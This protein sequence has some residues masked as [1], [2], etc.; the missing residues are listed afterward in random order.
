MVFG[1]D[2]FNDKRFAN[3]HQSG[4]DYRILGT[5]SI[6]QGSGA[7]TTIFPVFLG[8]GSTIIQWNPIPQSSQ[9]SNFRTHSGFFSDTWRV[10]GRLTANLGLR[11]DKNDGQ[12]Q[13]H[14]TV[15]T[16]DAWS[17]RLGLI[18]DPTGAG[19]LSIT[20]SVAKYVTAIAQSVAD[21]SAT[22]GNYQT[23]QFVYRGP[24]I[25]PLGTAA[26]VTPDVAIRQLFNWY[27][28]NG[29]ANLPLSAAP[30]IPGVTPIIGDLSSPYAWE[31]SAGVNRQFGQRAA[32]RVDTIYRDYQHPYADFTTAGRR[33]QDA[34]GRSYDYV[35][36]GNDTDLAKHRYA[37]LTMQG[38]YRW[39]AV[40]FGGNYTL[41]H[42]WGNMEGETVSSG[43]SGA[44]FQ[45]HRF[46]EYRQESW[47]Y[48]EGDLS[49]DQRHRSS[50]WVNYR[51]SGARGLTI[52]V[53]EL[54]NSGIPYGAGGRDAASQGSVTSGVD[55]RP[56]VTNPGYLTP[57]AG[58]DVIYYYTA[59]DAFRTASEFRTD[60]AANYA[61]RIPGAGSLELFAQIQVINLF[62]QSQLCAC[63]STAFATGSGGNA[64]GVN[65]QRLSTTVLTPVNTPA[66]FAAFN[67]FTTTPVRGV[68]WDL[69]PTFGQAV[70]R[71]AY[72]TPQSMRLS[73]GIRF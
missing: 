8:D 28:A 60:F 27:N 66:R 34:E 4:S 47:N 72:T 45:G 37:G 71:F 32:A 12:D 62:N 44:R 24:D 31:Y 59:R 61:H 6:I 19:R 25:N 18:F 17:P 5:S 57:P 46:P 40:D 21:F 68:N 48:P 50:L 53:L 63:G 42:N 13:S 64:G 73:F 16:E 33:V 39:Q 55:P 30:D 15:V 49:T 26:P 58:L 52:S 41:S 67:P 22:G 43:P 51:P 3:N 56:Y 54:M 14:R 20:G 36:I 1:Y 7:S 70:S 69:G 65:V 2:N 38:T 23:R 10:T 35:S 9:G 11:Y 29:G